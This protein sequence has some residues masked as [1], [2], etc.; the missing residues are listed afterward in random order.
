[1]SLAVMWLRG[2]GSVIPGPLQGFPGV[3]VRYPSAPRW[4]VVT[5]MLLLVGFAPGIRGQVCRLLDTTNVV[6][7]IECESVESKLTFTNVADST[8]RDTWNPARHP[9]CAPSI[10]A[11]HRFQ[12]D[13]A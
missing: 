13:V 10:L 8:A 7:V 12:G 4:V 3:A 11:V 6:Y 9:G 5:G 1:M 2:A